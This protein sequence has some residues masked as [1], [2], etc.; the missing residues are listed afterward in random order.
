MTWYQAMNQLITFRYSGTA[1]TAIPKI[2]W[3][4][5]ILPG[6]AGTFSVLGVSTPLTASQ[7]AYQ[8]IAYPSVGGIAG[9][10]AD[11]TF[12]QTQW[13]NAPIAFMNAI[14]V[15]PQYAALTTWATLA[16]SNYNSFQI[17]VTQRFAHDVDLDFNYTYGHSLDNASGLQNAGNYSTAAL[18]FNPFDLNSQYANSDFDIRHIINADW[19]V[20]LPF[21]RNKAF[22]HDSGKIVNGILGGWQ[23][24]GIFR[25]NSGLPT[26][27]PFGSQR[28]P[29][30][31]EISSTFVRANPVDTAPSKNVNGAPNLFANP[32]A[33][34]LSFRDAQPGE[35]GDRNV[36]TL[37]GYIDLDAG[38]TKSFRLTERQTLTFRWE[39]YNVTNTQRLTSP[40]GF[41][42]SPIDP[43][44]QGK[45][46][47]APITSAPATFGQLTSTQKPIGEGKAGRIM[48]FALRWEF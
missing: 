3:F 42:V 19:L 18:I 37:P 4:E 26:A 36:F 1:V 41:G 5:N 25:W 13:N 24:T 2:P 22:F 32:L 47:L 15:D 7:R 33:A 9:G 16:K 6:L 12:R 45:F 40:S 43:F 44:L 20:G 21:G 38:L 39:V 35:G 10:F 23:M 17:S 30:N 34:Y 8:R 27:S 29:T 11:Y 28:W 14:F 31:W 46:G 48:Q